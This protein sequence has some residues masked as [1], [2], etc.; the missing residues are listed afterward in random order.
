VCRYA[1][2]GVSR[3]ES[4]AACI[5]KEYSQLAEIWQEPP[6]LLIVTGSEPLEPIIQN[7]PIW[8]DLSELLLWGCEQ[9]PSILLSCLSA[10]AALAVF[11]NVA[12]ERLPLK[13]TGVF[14][15][16]VDHCHPLMTG[17]T[18]PIVLPHSRFNTV[19]LD[20]VQ[21]VGYR[22]ALQ[23]EATGWSVASKVVERSNVVLVQG[24]PEYEPSTLLREYRRDLTRYLLNERDDVPC[25]PLDCVAPEHSGTLQRFHQRVIEGE[26]D[27]ALLKLFPF[28]EV[29]NRAP[30]PWRATAIR[31]CENWLAR[32]PNR[33]Y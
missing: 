2:A 20:A 11:D 17:L 6:D 4:V 18:S 5:E 8:A 33:R 23:S 32:V 7:E 10:H 25:L 19:P 21:A 3:S 13:C 26:R 31:L 30:W 15:Q 24:H 12:R 1:M 16:E 14:P 22:V 27:S 9:V 29:A 28:A